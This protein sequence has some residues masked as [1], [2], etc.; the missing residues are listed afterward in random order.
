[1]KPFHLYLL[2]TGSWF[3]A[4]GIQSVMFAWLV[5][6][7]L[8]ETPQMVG[9]AQMTMLIPTML[10]ILVGGSLADIVGGR[11]IVVAAQSMAALAPLF[12]FIVVVSDNHS[13]R[14]KIN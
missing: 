7:V 8:H 1:V 6:M 9:I 4:F 13:F 5:T 14:S 2:G 10:L 12:L 11:R 3:L